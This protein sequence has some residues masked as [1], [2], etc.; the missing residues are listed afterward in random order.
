VIDIIGGL[1][2][3][4]RRERGASASGP[5]IRR[6]GVA[7][8]PRLPPPSLLTSA[9]A[10]RH[11]SKVPTLLHIVITPHPNATYNMILRS[12]IVAGVLAL[13]ASAFL[14]PLEVA[15]GV[16]VAKAQ[17]ESLWSDNAHTVELS[18]PGCTFPGPQQDG[19]GYSETDE[20]TI[21]CLVDSTASA[22]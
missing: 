9:V 17:L 7:L 22:P 5:K 11:L 19:I 3:C 10:V 13:Q 14:V 16:E 12:T 4:S 20:N 18:C 2:I 15:K 1:V 6:H 8:H 21:V